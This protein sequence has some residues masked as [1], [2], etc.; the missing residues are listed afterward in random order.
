[1]LFIEKKQLFSFNRKTIFQPRRFY[2][3]FKKN[4]AQ[5][6]ISKANI[7]FP[8]S[9]FFCFYFFFFDILPL[10]FYKRKAEFVHLAS[11]LLLILNIFLDWN[12]NVRWRL[13]IKQIVWMWTWGEVFTTFS[14]IIHMGVFKCGNLLPTIHLFMNM[15]KDIRV[16]AFFSSSF[17]PIILIIPIIIVSPFVF[18]LLRSQKCMQI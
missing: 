7:L 16:R 6:I 12:L 17:L 3:L 11:N 18:I 9:S 2:F 15:C 13:P 4:K 10:S 8:S 1:M 5:K 14:I